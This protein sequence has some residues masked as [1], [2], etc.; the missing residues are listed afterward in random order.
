MKTLVRQLLEQVEE[1]Q[2]EDWIWRCLELPADQEEGELTGDIFEWLEDP[3][4]EDGTAEEE[5][6]L[7]E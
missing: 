4:E 6:K 1:E 5:A 3:P 2:C 7:G